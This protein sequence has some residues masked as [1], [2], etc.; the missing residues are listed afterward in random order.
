[1]IP[2][3]F[4]NVWRERYLC[5]MYAGFSSF[6]NRDIHEPA[7]TARAKQ[8]RRTIYMLVKFLDNNE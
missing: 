8:G 1:M 3:I 7:V 5:G 6:M 4:I 2:N